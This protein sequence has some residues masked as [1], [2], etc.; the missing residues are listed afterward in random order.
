M[1][2]LYIVQC[3]KCGFQDRKTITVTEKCIANHLVQLTAKGSRKGGECYSAVRLCCLSQ[4]MHSQ[5][6]WFQNL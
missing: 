2:M 3:S 5:F 4:P 1:S 6:K